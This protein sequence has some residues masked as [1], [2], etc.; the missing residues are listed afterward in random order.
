MTDMIGRLE[1]LEKS[2]RRLRLVVYGFVAGT[3]GLLLTGAGQTGKFDG[4]VVRK[5]VIGDL[6]ADQGTHVVLEANEKLAVAK[7]AYA[8]DPNPKTK[9][10]RQKAIDA[11]LAAREIVRKDR[12]GPHASGGE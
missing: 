9:K 8:A 5:L 1:A 3:A 12:T 10:A 6:S 4:L 2:N 7:A 11:V